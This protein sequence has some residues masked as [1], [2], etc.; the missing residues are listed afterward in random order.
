MVQAFHPCLEV[1]L[2]EM[3]T[4]FVWTLKNIEA[5]LLLEVF[6]FVHQ[7]IQSSAFCRASKL[8]GSVDILEDNWI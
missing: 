3:S 2:W 4:F 7:G 8:Q 5:L 6:N 1:K